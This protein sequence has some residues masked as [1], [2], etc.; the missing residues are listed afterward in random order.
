LSEEV[1][2]PGRVHGQASAARNRTRRAGG[3]FRRATMKS[4]W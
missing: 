1:S 2:E 4:R 3:C